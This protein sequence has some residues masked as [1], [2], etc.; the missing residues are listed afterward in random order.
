MNDGQDL[1]PVPQSPCSQ[2]VQTASASI[3][4]CRHPRNKSILN[5]MLPFSAMRTTARELLPLPPT[6]YALQYA[7]PEE[8]PKYREN[9]KNYVPESKPAIREELL[10]R[11]PHPRH[12]SAFEPC[13]V[14]H[15]APDFLV[16]GEPLVGLYD[17][18]LS[19]DPDARS[20]SEREAHVDGEANIH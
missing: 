17:H 4:T 2:T 1:R 5:E 20:T 3:R 6:Q 19:D 16:F 15:R 8:H 10:V 13:A 12:F 9:P 14:P 11:L 18:D 7:Y